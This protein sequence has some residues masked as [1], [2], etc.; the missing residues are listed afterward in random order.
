MMTN[1]EKQQTAMAWFQ[2]GKTASY[3]TRKLGVHFTTAYKWKRM[4]QEQ[5]GDLATTSEAATNT[6]SKVGRPSQL[7]TVKNRLNVEIEKRNEE[8]KR[9]K[10]ALALIETF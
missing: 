9:F 6:V 3:V 8:I 2:Q 4:A 5:S 1:K 10:D 7:D